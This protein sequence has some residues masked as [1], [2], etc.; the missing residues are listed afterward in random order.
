VRAARAAKT[1]PRPDLPPEEEKRL[2]EDTIKELRAR[3]R[4]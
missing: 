2:P 4:R 1:A 3:R